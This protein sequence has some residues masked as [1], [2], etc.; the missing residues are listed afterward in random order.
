M[1][2]D[3]KPSLKA[4]KSLTAKPRHPDPDIVQKA[5]R[6]YDAGSS[7][8]TVGVALGVP[9]GT[10]HRWLEIPA[11][12]RQQPRQPPVTLTC[13][14]CGKSFTLLASAVRRGR[15]YCS[16]AC[17][18]LAT[19]VSREFTCRICGKAF[20]RRSRKLVTTCGPVCRGKAIGETKHKLAEGGKME[21]KGIWIA[22]AENACRACGVMEPLQIHHVVY[23]QHV[24]KR[25]GDVFDPRN[26]LTLCRI[27]HA[28]QHSGHTRLP[29]A[30]L[31]PE[32]LA[33]AKDLLGEYAGDYFARFYNDGH[34]MLELIGEAA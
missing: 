33:F 34:P 9:A 13:A 19:R 32:N 31:R 4:R 6:L 22:S 28:R 26:S 11:E 3:A 10:V 20:T 5:Q 8:A 7:F 1:V 15:K 27:C 25:A 2:R 21:R 30:K 24:R 17:Q 14:H 23:E 16:Q 29:V 12:R 18:G